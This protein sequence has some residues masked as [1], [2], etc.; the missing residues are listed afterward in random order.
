MRDSI[1][2]IFATL[3]CLSS[4]ML[5]SCTTETYD[6]GDGGLSYLCADF[7]EAYTNSDTI[8]TAA[9]TDDG[10]GLSLARGVKSKWVSVPDSL[11]RALLYYNKKSDPV[12][13]LALSQVP[14]VV[15]RVQKDSLLTD[16]MGVESVWTSANGKY[17][18]ISLLIKTGIPDSIDTRQWI[19]VVYDPE[20][21]GQTSDLLLL[22]SQNGVPEYYTTRMYISI[23]TATLPKQDAINIRVNTYGGMRTYTAKLKSEEK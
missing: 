4:L 23:P 10:V 14:V 2:S 6:T 11:Y 17:V 5:A 7:V 9:I 8:I 18:N 19:S 15:P 13:P 20:T 16:P 12:E 3:A 1:V 22:H 21:E